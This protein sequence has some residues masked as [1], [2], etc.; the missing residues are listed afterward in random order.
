MFVGIL[1]LL[2]GILI[3]KDRYFDFSTMRV[4][5]HGNPGAP[6]LFLPFITVLSYV[7]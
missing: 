4:I 2:M 6:Y 5:H 3:L 1:L 7:A